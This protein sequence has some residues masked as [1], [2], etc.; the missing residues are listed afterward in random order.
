MAVSVVFVLAASA[1]LSSAAPGVATRSYAGET[2]ECEFPKAGHVVIDTREP[3]SSITVGG[4][5]HP[6]QGGSYF[7]QSEDGD[8]VA[9]FKPDMKHWGFGDESA[10]PCR[11][12]PNP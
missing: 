11:V 9:Y 12:R 5:K 1:L 7:Y 10:V 4:K 8:V 2:V 3:G 6:A